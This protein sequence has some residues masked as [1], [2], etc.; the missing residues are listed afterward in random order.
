MTAGGAAA[1]ADH[2]AYTAR[3]FLLQPHID[4][5]SCYDRRWLGRN[6]LAAAC[7][8]SSVGAD[9]C[10]MLPLRTP[11]QHYIP[12]WAATAQGACQSACCLPAV[13]R[14]FPGTAGFFGALHHV[15]YHEGTACIIQLRQLYK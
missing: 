6:K 3:A 11:W 14:C 5:G 8:V 9:P 13:Q 15:G 12:T 2:T 1:H 4:C 10:I 7:N